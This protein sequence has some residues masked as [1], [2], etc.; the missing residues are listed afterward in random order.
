[1][2]VLLCA[3]WEMPV[4]TRA[5]QQRWSFF[6]LVTSYQLGRNCWQGFLH[7]L[8]VPAKQLNIAKP[9]FAFFPERYHKDI[10]KL[11]EWSLNAFLIQGKDQSCWY[12]TYAGCQ[13]VALAVVTREILTSLGMQYF[14]K[15]FPLCYGGPIQQKRACTA[16]LVQCFHIGLFQQDSAKQVVCTEHRSSR[17]PNISLEKL[18]AERA[19]FK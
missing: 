9:L 13:W 10:S 8:C 2:P 6:H 16:W 4:L 3:Q 14:P 1:M 11:A 17:E 5:G 19:N 12:V 18:P 7:W 15:P